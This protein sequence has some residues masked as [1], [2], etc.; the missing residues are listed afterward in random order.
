[1]VQKKV[2]NVKKL[3]YKKKRVKKVEIDPLHSDFNIV[4]MPIDS[5]FDIRDIIMNDLLGFAKL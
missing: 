4:N 3:T 2:R 5:K 1:M